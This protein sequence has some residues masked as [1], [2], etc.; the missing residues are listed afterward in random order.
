MLVTA[1]SLTKKLTDSARGNAA[2]VDAPTSIRAF[3]TASRRNR[4]GFHW[5]VI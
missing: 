3:F 5:P 4:D 2:L 1:M